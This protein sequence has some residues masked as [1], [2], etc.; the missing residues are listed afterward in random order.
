MKQNIENKFSYFNFIERRARRILPALFL[1]IFICLPFAYILLINEDLNKF[2]L[3][4]VAST[5]YWSN[6]LFF[7]ENLNYFG[8][9]SEYK[10]LL[11]TWSLSIEEQFYLIYPIIFLIFWKFNKKL[12][13]LILISV[14]IIS[15]FL[16]QMGA[17][18]SMN[19][20]FVE[21][22]MRFFVF[23]QPSWA[24]FYI[25]VSRIWELGIGAI[26]AFYANS[27]NNLEIKKNTFDEFFSILGFVFIFCSFYYFTELTPHPSIY[28]LIP[29]IGTSLIILYAKKNTLLFNLLSQRYVVLLGLLSYSAYL[30][31]YPF[32]VFMRYSLRYDLSPF[33]PLLIIVTFILSFLSWR[34]VE[35][36][37]RNFDSISTK[38]F[39]LVIIT[40]FLFLTLSG[41]YLFNYNDQGEKLNKAKYNYKNLEF[42]KQ[43]NISKRDSVMEKISTTADQFTSELI[44]KSNTN[45]SSDKNKN[46]I[47]IIGNSVSECLFLSFYLNKN[48]FNEFEFKYYRLHLSNFLKKNKQYKQKINYFENDK[49]FEDA[50]IILVSS[51][52]RVYG[53]YSEDFDA[54]YKLNELIMKKGKKLVLASNTPFFHSTYMPV[55]DIL[56]RQSNF[57]LSEEKISRKL[58][59]LIDRQTYKKNIKLKKIAKDLKITY[60]DKFDYMCDLSKEECF[61]FTDNGKA[62]LMD[63]LH[64]TVSG[65]KFF[66]KII[67]DIDWLKSLK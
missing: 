37:F 59:N 34:Y 67:N 20:P 58:F 55:T 23:N 47:L 35:K 3:S 16:T 21:S 45:F 9:A 62:L 10:P 57:M 32:F 44:R 42:D 66:G 5:T 63:S 22:K 18:L 14:S 64:Y 17:N 15:F 12:I 43:K 39:L 33:L 6:F 2:G 38:K 24:S 8:A 26:I 11:H 27:S 30:I 41:L 54:L 60:L 53:K 48:L 65:S 7:F 46:K 56:L 13:L 50:D 31:H 49:L 29:I 25:S 61:A 28:T 40:S 51:N 4:V 36:P 19:Y 52:F 1:I